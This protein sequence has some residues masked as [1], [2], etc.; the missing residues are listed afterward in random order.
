MEVS[1]FLMSLYKNRIVVTG[2]TGRFAASLKKVK[3]KYL[4]Y[5]PTKSNLNILNENSILKDQQFLL[6]F[7]HN[8]FL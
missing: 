8:F 3:T 6:L 5:F 7:D 4:V 1:G 2:G